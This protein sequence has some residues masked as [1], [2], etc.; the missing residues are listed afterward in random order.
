MTYYIDK[1]WLKNNGLISNGKTPPYNPKLIDRAKQL[2]K[3]M[4]KAECKLL[5]TI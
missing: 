3:E 1:D 4:T 2:R 5:T